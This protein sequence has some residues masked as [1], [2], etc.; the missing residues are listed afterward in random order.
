MRASSHSPLGSRI[1]PSLAILFGAATVLG[2]FGSPVGAQ[3]QPAGPPPPAAAPTQPAAQPATQPGAQPATGPAAPSAIPRPAGLKS[4][5]KLPVNADKRNERV[6]IR[7]LLSAGVV[8]QDR[9]AQFD[10][11]YTTYALARWTDPDLLGE[12]EKKP[13]FNLP[14]CRRELRNDLIT[15]R[16]GPVHDELAKLALDFLKTLAANP[17][18]HPASRYNATLAIGELN[19]TETTSATTRPVPWGPALEVLVRAFADPN[20]VDAV[21]VAALVGIFRHA[22]LGIADPQTRDQLRAG[23]LTVAQTKEDPRRSAEGQVWIR[24]RAMDVLG[25]LQEPGPQSSVAK[26]LAAIVADRDDDLVARRAAARALGKLNLPAGQGLDSSQMAAGLAQLAA[27]ACA[28]ELAKMEEEDEQKPTR[29]RLPMGMGG[30]GYMGGSGYEEEGYMPGYDEE[31][32]SG[33]GYGGAPM[34]SGYD[35]SGSMMPGMGMG[36]PYGQRRQEEEPDDTLNNRR[37][38]KS[39]LNAAFLGLSGV[40]WPG[41]ADWQRKNP[42][43]LGP[44]GA[45]GLVTA[46]G[47]M[48]LVQ[49]F[50]AQIDNLSKLCDNKDKLE[51]EEWIGELETQLGDLTE[52]LGA[53]SAPPAVPPR[54]TGQPARTQPPGVAPPPTATAPPTTAPP[55]TAPPTTAQP[56]TA[57][58]TTA[59][60]PTAPPTTIPPSTAPPTTA[61]PSTAPPTT[62]PPAAK[63]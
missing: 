20:Q 33:P 6:A 4:Y 49:G 63:P 21:R 61:P 26:A 38:L 44:G 57:P 32:G 41:W 62:A 45:A 16:N 30:P 27:D 29:S 11:Y 17:A 12:L 56:P 55:P 2:L 52:A 25:T 54:A 40:D 9:R 51:R 23:L 14:D 22:V 18:Y 58:P 43:V 3:N 10:E 60:P 59:P 13:N 24:A 7:K 5:A 15:G 19:A 37:R 50:I 46:Q 8:P 47:Q 42:G 35:E 1:G 34:G 48:N 39:F 28:A 31:M 36:Y 53:V